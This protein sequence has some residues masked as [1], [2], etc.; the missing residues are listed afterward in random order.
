MGTG[1]SG[2]RATLSRKRARSPPL[3]LRRHFG[4]RGHGAPGSR[5][6]P[7]LRP[8]CPQPIPPLEQRG[9]RMQL[10]RIRG[11]DPLDGFRLRLHLTQ[12]HDYRAGRPRLD[13]R[14]DLRRRPPFAGAIPRR[15]RRGRLSGLGQ[16][17]RSVLRRPDLGWC[18]ARLPQQRAVLRDHNDPLTRARPAF[19]PQ[20]CFIRVIA[21][22]PQRRDGRRGNPRCLRPRGPAGSE[23]PGTILAGPCRAKPLISVVSALSAPR[24]RNIRDG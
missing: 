6:A 16:W 18:T 14:T 20:H 2:G 12:R 1:P 4:R 21:V 8:G 23:T 22:L 17:R 11:V 13:A 9:R 5:R 3:V 10:I 24:R 7:Y 19:R 15:P